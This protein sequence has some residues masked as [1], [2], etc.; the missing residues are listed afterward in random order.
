MI[1]LPLPP[2]FL[3]LGGIKSFMTTF[4]SILLLGYFLYVKEYYSTVHREK[5]DRSPFLVP[6]VSLLLVAKNKIS[7]IRSELR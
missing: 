1:F 3:Q 2:P 6:P 5:V 4:T 7:N